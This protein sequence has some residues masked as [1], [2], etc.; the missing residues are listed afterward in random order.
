M[1]ILRSKSEEKSVSK[2]FLPQSSRPKEEGHS[3]ASHN[4]FIPTPTKNQR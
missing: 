3:N 1:R 2:E 4:F